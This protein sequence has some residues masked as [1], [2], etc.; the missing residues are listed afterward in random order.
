MTTVF[1]LPQDTDTRI[2]QAIAGRVC[3]A[4]DGSHINRSYGRR[5]SGQKA[6]YFVHMASGDSFSVYADTDEQAVIKATLKA[7]RREN[8]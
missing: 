2:E 6:R 1:S 3:T 8:G 5:R 7:E 4:S